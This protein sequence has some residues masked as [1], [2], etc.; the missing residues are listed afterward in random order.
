MKKQLF[1]ATLI[2]TLGL[3]A[4][5]GAQGTSG[6]VTATTMEQE[7]EMLSGEDMASQEMVQTEM[8]MEGTQAATDAEMEVST[9]TGVVEELKDFMFI[10]N[11]E[12]GASYAF[13]YT[14]ED[15]LDLSQVQAGDKVKVSFTGTVSEVD[16]FN[17]KVL[18]VEKVEE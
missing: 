7:A 5:C 3:A 11:D 17:G 14:A 8:D 9:V 15:G 18:S 6:D 12:A 13:S 2:V 4:G 10:I 16:A 1:T